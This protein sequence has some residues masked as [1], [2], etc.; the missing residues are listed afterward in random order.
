MLLRRCFCRAG[1]I[2][3]VLSMMCN[4]AISSVF[5][6]NHTLRSNRPQ[7]DDKS[8]IVYYIEFATNSGPVTLTSI[9]RG[10]YRFVVRDPHTIETIM[11]QLSDVHVKSTSII[12]TAIRLRLEYQG[13][14]IIMDNDGNVQNGLKAYEISPITFL[15]LDSLLQSSA[16]HSSTYGKVSLEDYSMFG[17]PVSPR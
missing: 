5:L 7:R 3:I 10:Q 17:K 15:R 16:K 8:L 9:R 6:E 4:H 11:H 2:T 14:L 13:N 12:P 1:S